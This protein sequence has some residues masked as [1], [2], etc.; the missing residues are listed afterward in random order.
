MLPI[1]TGD[2]VGPAPGRNIGVIAVMEF[3][4][5]PEAPLPRQRVSQQR[6]LMRRIG[7]LAVFTLLVV[8]V[9]KLVGA[10]VGSDDTQ[11]SAPADTAAPAETATD[12]GTGVVPSVAD[13]VAPAASTPVE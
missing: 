12:P 5:A 7:V 6:Y 4:D 13:T 9:I 1:R 2:V 10:V 8:G 3:D 11:A